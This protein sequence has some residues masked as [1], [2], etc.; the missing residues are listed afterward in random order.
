MQSRLKSVLNLLA[1]FPAMGQRT[2]SGQL[3]RLVVPPFPYVI[4]YQI[5]AEF[6][7]VVGVR[8]AAQDPR[9]NPS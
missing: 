8:H 1:D 9:S 2:T 5:D 7:T 3:R 6:I 4:F